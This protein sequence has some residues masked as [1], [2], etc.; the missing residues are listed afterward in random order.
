M[1]KNIKNSSQQE[2]I[3]KK[4]KQTARKGRTLVRAQSTHKS[5]NKSHGTHKKSQHKKWPGKPKQKQ[6][7]HTNNTHKRNTQKPIHNWKMHGNK[8]FFYVTMK[9]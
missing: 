3:I 4:I 9:G 5:I 6:T 2:G 1:T 7:Q 8:V